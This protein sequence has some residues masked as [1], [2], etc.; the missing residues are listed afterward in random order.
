MKVLHPDDRRI[1][2]HT[3]PE[4]TTATPMIDL[5]LRIGRRRRDILEDIRLARRRGDIQRGE[6]GLRE[7]GKDVM[8]ISR[9]VLGIL[10]V[11]EVDVLEARDEVVVEDDFAL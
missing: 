10:G 9:D 3:S 5:T 4:P 7:G 6:I 2:I 8:D 1:R 11:G